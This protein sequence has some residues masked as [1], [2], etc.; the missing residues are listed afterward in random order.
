MDNYVAKLEEDYRFVVVESYRSTETAELHGA[1]HIRPVKGHG[2]ATTL[3][4][5]CS[6]RM[7]NL[8]Y[9]P[10]GTKFRIHAKLTGRLD[11]GEFLY[12][13]FGWKFDVL[14]ELES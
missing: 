7:T 6:K 12:T 10:V 3:R 11:G 5:E 9:Y 14:N 2:I 1:I 13:W 4:V 8:K